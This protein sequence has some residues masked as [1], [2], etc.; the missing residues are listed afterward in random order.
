MNFEHKTRSE[1]WNFSDEIQDKFIK[2]QLGTKL[3][4]TF[5]SGINI[6]AFWSQ[7]ANSILKLR[8]IAICYLTL[9]LSTYLFEHG[10]STQLIIKNKHRDQFDITA[11]LRLTLSIIEPKILK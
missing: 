1:F 10:F 9:L 2:K 7:E 4:D 8:D 3:K 5:E 11:D 6:E